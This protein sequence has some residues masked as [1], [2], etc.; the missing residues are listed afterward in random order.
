MKY[1]LRS[2]SIV[3]LILLL[4]GA[5]CR[6]RPKSDIVT[7]LNGDR[8]TCEIKSL[9]VGLLEC[10]TDAMGTVKI[11]WDE[12]AGIASDYKFQV[13]Y[14]DGSVRIGRIVSDGKSDEFKV[15]GDSAV[16]N[17]PRLQ[18][19]ELRPLQTTRKD[20]MDVYL[21][22]GYDYTKASEST[23]VSLGL[24]IS[25][26]KE[27]SRSALKLRHTISDTREESTSSTKL[28]LFR[29]FSNE[30]TRRLFRYGNSSYESNDELELDYRVSLG[31]GFG[32]YFIDDN[33]RHLV[34][35]IGLQANTER[36]SAGGERDSLE[37]A[38]K[39]QFAT[40]Q[41]DTPELDVKFTLNLYPSLTDSGR[42]RG[43]SDIQLRWELYK[44]LFWDITAWSVYD[45]RTISDS[46]FD[47]GVST[48]IGW[49][50]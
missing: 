10:N 41:F 21:S 1:A 17:T 30:R 35:A 47:Y 20:A 11:E 2:S 22:A 37:G 31:G 49:D 18:I 33:K 14:S 23:Q 39:L 12:I 44:D 9:Y 26:E 13:R 19:A 42:V 45:N 8:V 48:G 43:D 6:A 5:D 34:S 25:Y 4:F 3:M 15:I 38:L 7:L 16:F 28:D 40:W 29:A 46:D 24:D 32:R 27:R 50:Y 36:D